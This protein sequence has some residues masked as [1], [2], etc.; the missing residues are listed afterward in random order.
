MNKQDIVENVSKSTGLS[1]R[2]SG[3]AVDSMIDAIKGSLKQGDKVALAG[4]GTFSV[5]QKKER[6]GRNPR[7]GETIRIPAS[8][9]PKFASSKGLKD[10]IK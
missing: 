10:S 1:L 9:A 7:T 4:F 6:T 8:K 2:Q 3:D 5:V